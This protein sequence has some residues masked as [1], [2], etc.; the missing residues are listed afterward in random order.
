MPDRKYAYTRW[1]YDNDTVQT[2]ERTGE[3]NGCGECCMALIR[4]T[5]IAWGRKARHE[6][7]VNGV[8]R[9]DRTG[10]WHEITNDKETRRYI[11]VEAIDTSEENRHRCDSLRDYNG[12]GYCDHHFDK[13]LICEAWPM[14]PEHVT[15][16]P[17][18]SYSFEV[19]GEWKIS[20]LDN[21]ATETDKGA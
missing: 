15:P 1:N 17:Q 3:C 19:T 12:K 6:D 7:A 4:L 2:L 16:F 11:K 8:T 18:C 13:T 14:A 9:H 5:S 10:T 20:E 21:E